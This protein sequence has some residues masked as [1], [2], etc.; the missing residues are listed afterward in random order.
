[1]K[2]QEKEVRKKIVVVRMN[3]NEFEQMEKLRKKSTERNLSSYVREVV[4]QKPVLIN[5]RNQSADE[6]LKDMLGLKKELNA[7]GNNFNQAVHKLHILDKIPEFRVWVNH[8]DGLHQS[9]V[10]KVEEI[11]LRMNQLY[12]EWLQK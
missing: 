10:N 7:I 8:Y 4:L 1:M 12:E 5:Y 9:L 6:F 3:D 2:K 11:K